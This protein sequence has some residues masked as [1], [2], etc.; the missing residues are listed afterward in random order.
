MRLSPAV[1]LAFALLPL[2]CKEKPVVT[3]P[4][5]CS[6]ASGGC[7]D[8]GTTPVNTVPVAST[9]VSEVHTL[10]D[11]T[12]VLEGAGTDAEGDALT[13]KWTQVSGP[14]AAL[15]AVEKPS[16]R[17]T[18]AGTYVFSLVVNDG[19]ADSAPQTVTV[20]AHDLNGG[21]AFT[22]ALKPDG[23]LW[24]WGY[25]GDSRLGDGTT[26]NRT[27]P[28]RV[29]DTGATDCAAH[30]F[31]GAVAIATGAAHTLVLKGDGTVWGW[32][33]NGDGQ[34]GDGTHETR[35]TPVPVCDVGATD[36]AAHP[37]TGVVAVAA[38]YQHS[39]ALKAD[40][41]V[42][43]W[44]RNVD[45]EVGDGSGN[46]QVLAPVNVCAVGATAPCTAVAGN[47]L[48]DIRIL[49]AGGGGH[50]LAV[51]AQGA[52]FAWGYN[53][54]GQVGVG[55]SSNRRV[56]T[57]EPVCAAG[58]TS[59]C[60]KF[61]TGIV[62]V[63]AWSG[64]SLAIDANG[65]LWGWG[66]NND[67]ELSMVTTTTCY[68][69]SSCTEVPAPVCASVD[70]PCKYS[71]ALLND[72]TIRTWGNNGFGQLGDGTTENRTTGP[73][74]VCAVGGEVPC[75]AFLSDI[76]AISAGNY[77]SL[78]LSNTGHL[79]AW[80]EGATGALGDG[81]GANASVPVQVTGY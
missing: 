81:A 38:G 77:H 57:P 73:V 12:I 42:V 44:G 55:D 19:Q 66:G 56:F 25:N 54:S 47:V 6:E 20:F 41:T 5:T 10:V 13:L 35:S 80:G 14:A 50:S 32:G 3:P 76:A 21:D 61:L 68:S 39:M 33:F 17:F 31:S 7:P 72:G 49:A 16:I 27:V 37:L 60:T 4:T 46:G 9:V 79:Y 28:V 11:R 24:S 70:A 78:A 48:K 65:A 18:R 69:G 2:A 1:A 30:P 15:A 45:G 52:V 40:G 34:V 29:C 63:D 43:G 51:G 74:R 22:V 26:E 53:K 71:L 62:D 67:G 8:A 75:T 59:P 36:C 58:E 23:T 64:S